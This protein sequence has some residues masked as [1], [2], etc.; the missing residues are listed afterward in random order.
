[1]ARSLESIDLCGEVESARKGAEGERTGAN[2]ARWCIEVKP[3]IRSANRSK[4]NQAL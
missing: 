2:G 1:M 4:D 3:R